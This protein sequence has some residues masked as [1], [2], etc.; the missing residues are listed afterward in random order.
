MATFHLLRTKSGKLV[1]TTERVLTPD[2]M[3]RI[4]NYFQTWSEGPAGV[5]VIPDCVIELEVADD[6]ITLA[7]PPV[8]P[9]EA[10]RGIDASPP[11]EVDAQ[12]R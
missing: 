8:A 12:S 3:N 2:E 1:V 5:L 9:A 10:R 11:A 6:E 7:R 4:A